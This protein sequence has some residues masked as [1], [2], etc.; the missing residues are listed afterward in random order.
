M[1]NGADSFEKKPT[2]PKNFK[3]LI[4]KLSLKMWNYIKIVY[5]I[6]NYLL[7]M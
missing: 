6:I 5:N 4:A 7:L 2:M 3:D 1:I